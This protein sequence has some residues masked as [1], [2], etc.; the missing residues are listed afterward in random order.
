[1]FTTIH[2]VFV[3]LILCPGMFVISFLL[4]VYGKF[5]LLEGK[6]I[7]DRFSALYTFSASYLLGKILFS[8]TLTTTGGSF[9]GFAW[10]GVFLMVCI[11]QME[12]VSHHNPLY[13]SPPHNL[14]P[15]SSIIHPTN[16]RLTE[17]FVSSDLES[18]ATHKQMLAIQDEI[19]ELNRRRKIVFTAS[20]F[21]LILLL[22]GK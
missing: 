18:E 9:V 7:H 8:S 12:R 6:T 5:P 4:Y 14:V 2:K 10:V 16:M 19:V 20:L 21:F 11:Y 17:Y 22:A 3:P 15:I 13:V 1:M